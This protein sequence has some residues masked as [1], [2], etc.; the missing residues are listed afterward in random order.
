MIFSKSITSSMSG[1]GI[2]EDAGAED[3]VG[4]VRFTL[5]SMDTILLSPFYQYVYDIQIVTNAGKIHTPES[6]LLTSFSNISA[7][8]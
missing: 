4:K 8:E 7:E 1:G 6:G 5:L 3:G 2:I